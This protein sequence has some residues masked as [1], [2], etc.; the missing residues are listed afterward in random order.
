LI[1]RALLIRLYLSGLLLVILNRSL[2]DPAAKRLAVARS[3]SRRT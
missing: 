3:T 2:N 1:K